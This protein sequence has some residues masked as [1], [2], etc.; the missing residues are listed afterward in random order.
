MMPGLC[1]KMRSCGVV[2]LVAVIEQSCVVIPPL[3]SF[4]DTWKS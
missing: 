2:K 1:G 3:V 4:T